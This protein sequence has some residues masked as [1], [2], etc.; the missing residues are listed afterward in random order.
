MGVV[1]VKTEAQK[2]ARKNYAKKCRRMV[3]TIYPSEP[4]MMKKINSVSSYSE[5]VKSLIAEDIEREKKELQE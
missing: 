1:M 3:I 2:R 4:E 5:Y